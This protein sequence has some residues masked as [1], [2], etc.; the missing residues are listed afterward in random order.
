MQHVFSK[1]CGL[2]ILSRSE[3]C[4]S[5]TVHYATAIADDSCNAMSLIVRSGEV[6]PDFLLNNMF[7]SQ[8]NTPRGRLYL[9][10]PP[11]F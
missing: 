7:D 3:E 8:I 2:K 4:P 10:I 1:K 11:G 6:H 5:V 9:K